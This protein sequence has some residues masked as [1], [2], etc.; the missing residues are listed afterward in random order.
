MR[1]GVA[2]VRPAATLPLLLLVGASASVPASLVGQTGVV[3]AAHVGSTAAAPGGVM[4]DGASEIRVV[5]WGLRLG[6]GM[7]AAGTALAPVVSSRESS[8]G[9]WRPDERDASAEELAD[10]AISS[11]ERL[12]GVRYRWGGSSPRAGFDC[13]GF[14]QYVFRLQGIELPR[15]SRRQSRAGI[16]LET[17]FEG[18]AKGDLLF[19]ALRGSTVDHV[20]I[21]TGDGRMVHASSSGRGVRYDDFTSHRGRWYARRLVAVRRVIIDRDEL[22]QEVPAEE[23]MRGVSRAVPL[24]EAVEAITGESGDDNAPP[25]GH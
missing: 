24:G 4:V 22:V 9:A 23:R 14:V 6:V 19:F 12:I 15:E 3:L 25:P 11:A 16:P 18:L 10:A 13:S 1:A 2:A 21:H 20:A 7:D 5:L 8:S 17:S